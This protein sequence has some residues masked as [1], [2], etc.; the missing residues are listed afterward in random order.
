MKNKNSLIIF[1]DL[2]GT[3]LH[4]KT[5]KFDPIKDF[6]KDKGFVTKKNILDYLGWGV[7]IKFSPYR[8]A[9][10]KYKEIKFTKYGYEWIGE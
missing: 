7:R 8:N 4:R 9:L 2:D 5:F 3:L 1:T 6:I 10:R